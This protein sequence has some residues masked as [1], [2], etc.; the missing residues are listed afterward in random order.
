[1]P[2]EAIVTA[3][4]MLESFPEPVQNKIVEHLRDYLLE[5]QDELCWDDLLNK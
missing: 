2:S 1:M 3:V 4:K 5:M